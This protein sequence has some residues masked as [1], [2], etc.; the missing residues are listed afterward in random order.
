MPSLSTVTCPDC[1]DQ[2]SLTWA[3]IDNGTRHLDLFPR[4]C[5]GKTTFVRHPQ[6]HNFRLRTGISQRLRRALRCHHCPVTFCVT[7]SAMETP[8]VSRSMARTLSGRPHLHHSNWFVLVVVGI[9]RC[10]S[11]FWVVP[12]FENFLLIRSA[13]FVQFP[14]CNKLSGQHIRNRSRYL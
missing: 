5:H 10:H 3:Q 11:S 6:C 13:V 1:F 9:R 8:S 7:D 12:L 4:L 14:G 2:L